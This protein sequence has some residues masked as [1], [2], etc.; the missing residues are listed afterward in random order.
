MLIKNLQKSPVCLSYQC[1]PF[2]FCQRELLTPRH[3]AV[4]QYKKQDMSQGCRKELGEHYER[5]ERKDNESG[6]PRREITTSSSR[7][8][9]DQHKPVAFLSVSLACIL[10]T[11]KIIMICMI[12]NDEAHL[13]L[14]LATIISNYCSSRV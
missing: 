7:N 10:I 14:S 2:A 3:S 4:G 11:M 6:V 13:T 5:R 12:E 8:N 1:R 9:N